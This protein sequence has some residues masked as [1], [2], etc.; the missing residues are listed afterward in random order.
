M[1]VRTPAEWLKQPSA[2][3]SLSV[4]KRFAALHGE[5]PCFLISVPDGSEEAVDFCVSKRADQNVNIAHV[6]PNVLIREFPL[7][8][9]MPIQRR[10]VNCNAFIEKKHAQIAPSWKAALVG[11]VQFYLNSHTGPTGQVELSISGLNIVVSAN[12]PP[13]D[14]A[15][16][17]GGLM[18]ISAATGEWEKI[19]P[20]NFCDL[21]SD[22][23][24]AF[25]GR[26][27]DLQKTIAGARIL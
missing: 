20:G 4:L 1:T 26:K 13:S 17:V 16:T 23:Q 15:L 5:T 8:E 9:G 10:V 21:C 27:E 18:A 22:A 25:H 19:I 6:D 11:A 7:P 24:D 2:K 3:N 12:V 14:T